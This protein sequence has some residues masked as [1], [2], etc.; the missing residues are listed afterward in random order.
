M[1]EH[2]N[3]LKLTT[4]A[5]VFQGASFGIGLASAGWVAVL[6]CEKRISL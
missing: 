2:K 1:K 4:L 3:F 6:I 5:D